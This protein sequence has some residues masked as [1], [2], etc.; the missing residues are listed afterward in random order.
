MIAAWKQY[1]TIMQAARYADINDSRIRTWIKSKLLAEYRFRTTSFVH[2]GHFVD[3]DELDLLLAFRK[4]YDG[5]V[6]GGFST[7]Q[8]RWEFYREELLSTAPIIPTFTDTSDLCVEFETYVKRRHQD[9][10]EA[11]AV[12]DLPEMI[13]AAYIDQRFRIVTKTNNFRSKGPGYLLKVDLDDQTQLRYMSTERFHF[14]FE[15][16]PEEMR[17]S[18]VYRTVYVQTELQVDEQAMLD[19]IFSHADFRDK[20]QHLL[21][22]E[23]Q[24]EENILKELIEDLDE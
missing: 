16:A 5:V 11:T 18:P 23:T 14:S 17:F 24:R 21:T 4:K 12:Q 13:V 19:Y 3:P 20:V 10:L 2:L 1:I 22:T 8:D 7:W 6:S 15:L 9:V